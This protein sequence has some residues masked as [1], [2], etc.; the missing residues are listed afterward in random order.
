MSTLT[1]DYGN[2]INSLGELAPEPKPITLHGY[3]VQYIAPTRP[4]Y[5]FD[6]TCAILA[7]DSEFNNDVVRVF[8]V[9][10]P[11]ENQR[12]VAAFACQA[13]NTHE[14]LVSALKRIVTA[15][16]QSKEAP[17]PKSAISDI[18]A[19]IE[20]VRELIANLGLAQ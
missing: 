8:D 11:D 12:A 17:S 10:D 20:P 2:I 7:K 6:P 9:P 16:D 5:T 14:A 3:H 4:E 19:A 1:D 13:M 18:R 15:Y